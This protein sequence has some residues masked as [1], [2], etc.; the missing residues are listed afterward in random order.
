MLKTDHFS[1]TQ[2]KGLASW[3][4]VSLT[5]ISQGCGWM[6]LDRG[7][8]PVTP[9]VGRVDGSPVVAASWRVLCWGQAAVRPLEWRKMFVS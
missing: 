8:S 2:E 5:G 4:S 7:L 6:P 9:A 3:V 1:V